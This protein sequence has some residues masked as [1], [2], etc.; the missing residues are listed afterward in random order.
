MFHLFPKVIGD[1]PEASQI[2][3]RM[4]R[5]ILEYLEEISLEDLT[6]AEVVNIFEILIKERPK[7]EHTQLVFDE[8]EKRLKSFFA[9]LRIDL[10]KIDLNKSSGNLEIVC[11]FEKS[12]E[13]T[14]RLPLDIFKFSTQISLHQNEEEL[15]FCLT[16]PQVLSVL[17]MTE[18]LK[19]K[20][21][22]EIE[23]TLTKIIKQVHQSLELIESGPKDIK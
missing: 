11:I 18:E 2:R 5:E 20:I 10:L 15:K 23:Q 16:F 21:K 19:E 14:K 8:C 3:R 4:S 22:G 12:N 17:N 7:E 6:N 13:D 1:T 9:E